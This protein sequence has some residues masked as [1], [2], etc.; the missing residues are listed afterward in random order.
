MDVKYPR[1]VRHQQRALAAIRIFAGAW[2][3]YV[4]A[5]KLDPAWVT[6]FPRVLAAY[7]AATPFKPYA[8]FL[9]EVVMPSAGLFA[10]LVILGEL[11]VGLALVLGLF[12]APAALL[13]A[14]L[15]ANFLLASAGSGTAA[16]GL[17]LAFIVV[18]VALAFGYAGTTW[19]LDARLVGKLPWW[20]QGLVHY[21]NR[22]F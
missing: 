9:T 11:A 18:L 7:A 12:T 2:F 8:A 16:V 22:E 3:L 6:K 10:S 21:E 1:L 14:V 5:A 19:G 4:V 20:C 13:G 17:N 15:V